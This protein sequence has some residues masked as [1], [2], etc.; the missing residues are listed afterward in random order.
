MIEQKKKKTNNK[1]TE[2]ENQPKKERKKNLWNI[3]AMYQRK[4]ERKNQ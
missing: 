4:K 3:E 2:W 1:V